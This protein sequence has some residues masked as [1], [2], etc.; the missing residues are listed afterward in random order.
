MIVAQEA[1][2][3]AD[4]VVAGVDVDD[5]PAADAESTLPSPTPTV[6]PLP[7]SQELP[8][9]SHVISIPPPSPIAEPS[10]PSQQQQ[11]S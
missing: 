3:V 6:Q 8:S 7:P 11:L 2:D 5:V 4:E 10:S 1:D 9:T